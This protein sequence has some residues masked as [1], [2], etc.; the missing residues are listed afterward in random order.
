[1]K[2][3]YPLVTE[4]KQKVYPILTDSP[5]D[6]TI[7]RLPYIIQTEDRGQLAINLADCPGDHINTMDLADFLIRQISDREYIRKAPFIAS[8]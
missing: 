8:V 4:D 5:I 2:R 3:T 1:M 7:V 6:W